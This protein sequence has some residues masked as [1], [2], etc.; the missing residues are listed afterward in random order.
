[1]IKSLKILSIYSHFAAC[2]GRGCTDNTTPTTATIQE[3]TSSRATS[4]SSSCVDK[5]SICPYYAARGFCSNQLYMRSCPKSCDKCGN[6][7]CKDMNSN[8]PH[9]KRHCDNNDYM[10]QSCKFTCGLC[11]EKVR[12]L[13][14]L[15]ERTI[16]RNSGL[17][18]CLEFCI[19]QSAVQSKEHSIDEHTNPIRF[20][21][22][23]LMFNKKLFHQCSAN[24]I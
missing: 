17:W 13:L 12:K 20:R 19:A 10:V 9:W 23:P 14:K 2:V 22:Y 8:C 1:M 11:T 5:Y 7:V 3:V 15:N 6:E 4:V 16:K 21:E 24:K 18:I